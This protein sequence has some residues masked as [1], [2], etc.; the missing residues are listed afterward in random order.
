MVVH[1]MGLFAEGF[2]MIKA[3][4]KKIEIRLYDSKRQQIKT[5]D[6]IVFGLLPD[7]NETIKVQVTGVD[8]Y[9]DFE[10]L[11]REVDF[12]LLGRADKTHQWMLDASYDYYTKEDEASYGVVAI[13]F[14]VIP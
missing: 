7:K 11:Y 8:V 14:I 10:T 1:E 4:S 13:S 2:G 12:A 6:C 9:N 3:G 5:G